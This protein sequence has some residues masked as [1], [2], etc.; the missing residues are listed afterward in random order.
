MDAYLQPGWSQSRQVHGMQG[1]ILSAG[2]DKRAAVEVQA[3]L[4]LRLGSVWAE[5]KELLM[6]EHKSWETVESYK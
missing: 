4:R 6:L 3:L 2:K 5:G 1:M